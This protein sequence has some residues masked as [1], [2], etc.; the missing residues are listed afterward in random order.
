MPEKKL[1][2]T[3]PV[4]LHAR[5]ASIFVRAAAKF[6]CKIFISHGVRTS[7][8]KSILGVLSLGVQKDSE[9]ILKTEGEGAEE[10]LIFLE[11]LIKDDFG[12]SK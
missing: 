10:A 2:V 11:E 8:A 7:N 6:K 9:I 12:D 4:G 5:P 1:I 3:H